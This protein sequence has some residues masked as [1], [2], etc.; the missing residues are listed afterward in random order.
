[1]IN[2][3]LTFFKKSG[4]SY[5]LTYS[6]QMGTYFISNDKHEILTVSSEELFLAMESIFKLRGNHER[7]GT[8]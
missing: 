1:M 3:L 5:T 4:E 6:Q 2:L 7:P 8:K